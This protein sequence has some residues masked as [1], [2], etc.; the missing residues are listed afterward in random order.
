M[1]QYDIANLNAWMCILEFVVIII[2]QGPSY[3]LNVHTTMYIIY[4]VKWHS[5]G[6]RCIDSS[7][8]T[9]VSVVLLTWLTLT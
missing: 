7:L 8:T 3:S 4:L 2:R 1:L 6:K 9:W 5:D